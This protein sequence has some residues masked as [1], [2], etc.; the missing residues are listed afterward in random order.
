LIVDRLESHRAALEQSERRGSL[1][2]FD[3]LN[4]HERERIHADFM[5]KV[6]LNGVEDLWQMWCL[7]VETLHA[8]GIM[9]PH[10]QTF[11]LYDGYRLSDMPVTFSDSVWYECRLCQ[12]AVINR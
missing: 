7:Y 11:R 8:W 5:T 12:A 1:L 4:S 3:E 6:R 10:P 9:C 2:R